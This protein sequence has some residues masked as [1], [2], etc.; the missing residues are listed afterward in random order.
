MKLGREIEWL[1]TDTAHVEDLQGYLQHKNLASRVSVISFEKLQELREHP[2][3]PESFR[4][5]VSKHFTTYGKEYLGA[6]ALIVAAG[7]AKLKY[8]SPNGLR[9]A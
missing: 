1:A 5:R 8:F 3:V 2:P 4:Q 7:L 9:S 6:L